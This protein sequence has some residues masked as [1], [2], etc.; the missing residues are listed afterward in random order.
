MKMV[1]LSNDLHKLT[2]ASC[3]F[4]ELSIA[5]EG[6]LILAEVLALPAQLRKVSLALATKI[7]NMEEEPGPRRKRRFHEARLLIAKC[8]AM[9]DAAART[10]PSVAK[11]CDAAKKLLCF[12]EEE[13][14]RIEER[15]SGKRALMN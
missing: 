6:H 14:D 10:L 11:L 7:W 3:D 5:L 4:E 8:G 13:L 15:S 1:V 12:M 9:V 2:L